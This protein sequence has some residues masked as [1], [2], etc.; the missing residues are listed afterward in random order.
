MLQVFL[1]VFLEAMEHGTSEQQDIRERTLLDRDCSCRRGILV[2]RVMIVSRVVQF[3]F[4]LATREGTSEMLQTWLLLWWTVQLS[5][6][7]LATGA[8]L[9][10]RE[11]TSEMLQAWLL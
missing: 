10:T 5:F 1:E 6:S 11:G 4:F 9:A 8:R 2:L 7:M 3:S